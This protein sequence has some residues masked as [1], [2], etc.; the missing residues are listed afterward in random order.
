[1]NAQRVTPMPDGYL[2]KQ[3]KKIKKKERRGRPW[4]GEE[5]G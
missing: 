4:K 3:N 2:K 5:Y 1:M